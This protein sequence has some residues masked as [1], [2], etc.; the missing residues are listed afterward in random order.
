MK[1]KK[2]WL[3]PALL[4]MSKILLVWIFLFDRVGTFIGVLGV[5][6]E[7]PQS[8]YGEILLPQTDELEDAQ[9]PSTPSQIGKATYP[10]F[11]QEIG[12]ITIESA[13]IVAPVIQGDNDEILEVAVGHGFAYALPGENGLVVASAH[14]NTLFSSLGEVEIGDEIL[15]STYWGDYT[16][17]VEEQVIF[18]MDDASLLQSE[19][20]EETLILYTCYPFEFIGNAPDRYAIICSLVDGAEVVW[21]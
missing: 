12:R 1:Q 3:I 14:R 15:F 2:I 21:E 17:R 16:Y 19:V 10:A 5:L 9:E 7:P 8:Q 6:Q 13:N 18:H 11:G 20:S 4:F